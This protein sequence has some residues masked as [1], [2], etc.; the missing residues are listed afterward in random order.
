LRRGVTAGA[1][2][3]VWLRTVGFDTRSGPVSLRRYVV[4]GRGFHQLGVPIVGDRAGTLGL[5]MLALASLVLFRLVS[6][7]ASDTTLD[8]FSNREEARVF[9]RLRESTSQQSERS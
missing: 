6:P 4:G 1:I 3:A 7:S 8:H 5:V 9:S 2:D